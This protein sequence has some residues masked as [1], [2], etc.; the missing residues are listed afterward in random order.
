MGKEEMTNEK[1]KIFS[2]EF[3]M[4]KELIKMDREKA[5]LKH[6]LKMEELKYFRETVKLNHENRMSEHRIKRADRQ[7]GFLQER[8]WEK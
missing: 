1:E 8:K 6:K 4:R 2:Q 7:R 3:L 5:E